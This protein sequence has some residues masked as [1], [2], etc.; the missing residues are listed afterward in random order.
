M[1]RDR[2]V[3]IRLTDQEHAAL[4]RLGRPSDVLR[5]VLREEARPPVQQVTPA[6]TLA[7]TAPGFA[8]W[9]DGTVGQM[10]PPMETR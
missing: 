2:I 9:M 6:S 1:T 8:M 10:W 4:Q 5:R 7:P 3:S